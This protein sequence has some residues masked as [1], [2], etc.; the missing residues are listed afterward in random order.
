LYS[1]AD[2]RADSIPV[3]IATVF[4]TIP[5]RGAPSKAKNQVEKMAMPKTNRVTIVI[6]S[7]CFIDYPFLYLPKY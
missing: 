1:S 5:A 6:I 2:V 4:R 7:E 3:T